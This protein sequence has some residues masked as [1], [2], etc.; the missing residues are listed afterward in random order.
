MGKAATKLPKAV[1]DMSVLVRGILSSR[2]PTMIDGGKP[3]VTSS[4]TQC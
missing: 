4:L 3:L 1:L 2:G